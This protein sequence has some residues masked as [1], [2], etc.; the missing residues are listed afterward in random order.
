MTPTLAPFELPCRKR[1]ER[2]EQAVDY[3]VTRL[4]E[5]AMSAELLHQVR[6]AERKIQPSWYRLVKVQ[7]IYLGIG[8]VLAVRAW[9]VWRQR[10]TLT[11]YL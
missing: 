2:H 3:L 7:L 8:K 11:Y 5:P 1:F 10:S 6:W 4:D 9:K